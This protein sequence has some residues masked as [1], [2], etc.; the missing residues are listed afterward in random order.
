LHASLDRD[1]VKQRRKIV[2]TG[3]SRTSGAGG[4]TVTGGGV[5]RAGVGAGGS[6]MGLELVLLPAAS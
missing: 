2:C 6:S 1:K 3:T 5:F 4:S